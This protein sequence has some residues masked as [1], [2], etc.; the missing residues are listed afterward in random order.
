MK[1]LIIDDSFEF[2]DPLS[3]ILEFEGYNTKII[4]ESNQIYNNIKLINGFDLVIL[5]VMMELCVG[6]NDSDL[7]AGVQILNKIREI[8]DIP[9]IM[10]S[11]YHYSVIKDGIKDLKKMYY[12]TKPISPDMNEI[13]EVIDNKINF[14]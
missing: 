4:A 3:E 1:I 12:L 8:S 5:D 13:F 10:I 7:E 14:N 2:S 9:V 6:M 11:A